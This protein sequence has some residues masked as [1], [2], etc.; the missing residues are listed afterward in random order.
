MYSRGVENE[1]YLRGVQETDADGTVTFVSIFP[2]CY[3]GR[4]PHLH[5]EVYASLDDATAATEPVATSQ[6]AFPED[7]CAVVY[8]SDGYSQS[9]SNL[10]G[11]SLDGD[12]VFA[13][14]YAQQL[15]T[16]SGSVESGYTATLAVPV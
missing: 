10:A 9:V 16:M 2:G 12:M 4:W 6:L 13:D 11:V 15:A 7:V 3:A 14:S 8:A 1:N 5:F